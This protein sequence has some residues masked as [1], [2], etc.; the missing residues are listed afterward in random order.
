MKIH[1]GST[2]YNPVT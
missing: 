2:F 1:D